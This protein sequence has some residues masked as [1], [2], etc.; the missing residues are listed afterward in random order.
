MTEILEQVRAQIAAGCPGQAYDLAAS[1]D[2]TRRDDPALR[3]LAALALA[4]GGNGPGA[5]VLLDR[6]LAESLPTALW[7]EAACLRA[8]L[9]KDDFERNG[10]PEALALAA[11]RYREA[12][13]TVGEPYPGINAASLAWL[14]GR[15]EEA[16]TLAAALLCQLAGP[17]ADHWATATRAEALLL[18]GRRDEAGAA[19]AA[20]VA[21]AGWRR[22]DVASMRRQLLLLARALDVSDLL[23]V[24]NPGGVVAF[25]GHLIDQPGASQP[26]F[27]DDATVIEA[28]AAALAAALDRRQVSLGFCSGACGADL[29]FAEAVLAR[30]GELHIVLPFDREDFVRTSVDYG[31]PARSGWRQR[32][33]Q[34]LNRAT[35]VHQATTERYLGDRHLFGFCDRVTQGLAICGAQAWHVEPTALVL[36]DP[37]SAANDTG[38]AAFARH[39]QSL[40][41][42]IER[43]DLAALRGS[44]A[45]PPPVSPHLAPAPAVAGRELKAMLFADVHGFGRLCEE[46]TP[47]FVSAFL[48]QVAAALSERSVPPRFANTWGD[49]LFLVFDDVVE[50]AEC[51]TALLARLRGTDWS[52]HGL[53]TPAGLRIGLH[54]GPVY[55]QWDPVLGRTNYFGRHVTRAARIEQVGTPGC[56][57]ASEPFAAALAATGAHRLHC[58][59][60]GHH[61]L[62]KDFD[63]CALY[64][65]GDAPA[66]AP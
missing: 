57:F 61:A 38:T 26:R 10:D 41:R 64:R 60:L 22:G 48:D 23:A 35:Q 25:S 46:G 4:R 9:A 66:G 13:Q 19:Y 16:R 45:G 3:Y 32:F 11:L 18:L 37:A 33:E 12:Y 6:L 59:Y 8:R 15:H 44:P 40:G 34:V 30:G 55:A 65:L 20:A 43:L 52:G 58:V 49:G 54:A 53:P 36:L 51:A 42:P 56:A 1:A 27:P 14:G 62:A 29:L 5:S 39:W 31:A 24:V 28:A 47:A 2:R 50:C 7:T 17:A 21:Q 63:T